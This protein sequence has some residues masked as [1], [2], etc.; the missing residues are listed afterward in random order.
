MNER[1]VE[2]VIKRI[3]LQ[4]SFSAP[5]LLRLLVSIYTE[6][7]IIIIKH[8]YYSWFPSVISSV[9][10]KTS[11]QRLLNFLMGNLKEFHLGDIR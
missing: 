3:D 1:S 11:E 9:N 10:Y 4:S 5:D 2:M 8:Y 6:I 7:T